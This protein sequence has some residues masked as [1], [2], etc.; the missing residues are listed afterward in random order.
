MRYRKLGRTGLDV[1]VIG[2]GASPLGNVFGDVDPQSAASAV[3]SAIES[4]INYFD[5]SPY[6]GMT[7]AEERL[8]EALGGR[9]KDVLLS[10][11][12]GRY[13]AD[14]FDFSPKTITLAFES[15]LRRLR[16]DHVDLLLAHDIEFADIRQIVD[17]TIPSMQRLKEQGKVRFI[18]ITGYWPGLL[19]RVASE[20]GVD[21]VMNYCHS[22][23]F[24][25]DMDVELVPAVQRLGIG[26]I[27]ASPLH[28]GLLADKPLPAWHPAPVSVRE[29]ALAIRAACARYGV[30]AGSLAIHICL[31]HLGVASTLVG[32]SSESE[33]IAACAAIDWTPPADL[34]QTVHSLIEPVHNLVWPSGLEA[35]QD[36]F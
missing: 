15:S 7:L 12:C 10:T 25:N 32:I 33:V 36:A 20:V 28:M 22:N 18:G 35:N 16:T 6:Y 11:K 19:A 1:S 13:G 26:L 30:N 29:A 5:V 21:C 34:L 27:N 17:E 14:V 4:G 3:S 23:L 8:G 31:Q 9:R 2:F 24:I